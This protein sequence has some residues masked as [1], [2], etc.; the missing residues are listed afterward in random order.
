MT[1]GH[2]I[3]V[4]IFFTKFKLCEGSNQLLEFINVKGYPTVQ[5]STDYE[6]LMPVPSA[7]IQDDNTFAA[8][9]PGEAVFDFSPDRYVFRYLI[10]AKPKP[11]TI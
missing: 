10:P 4:P 6:D 2:C 9:Y 7:V 3:A 11:K 8:Y 1:N 5:M